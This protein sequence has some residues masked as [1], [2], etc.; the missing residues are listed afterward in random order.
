MADRASR[1]TTFDAFDA[2]WVRARLGRRRA[3][4]KIAVAD[5]HPGLAAHFATGRRAIAG[6]A[7]AQ[8]RG[9]ERVEVQGRRRR[10]GSRPSCSP[11]DEADM[12]RQWMLP[13]EFTPRLASARASGR[14][15]RTARCRPT[16]TAAPVPERRQWL[17]HPPGDHRLTYGSGGAPEH[18]IRPAL[19]DID[20]ARTPT[21]ARTDV[22]SA[23]LAP[24]RILAAV[25]ALDPHARRVRLRRRPPT[26]GVRAAPPRRA[27]RRRRAPRQRCPD[28]PFG[29][30]CSAVPPTARAASRAWPTTR[31]HGAAAA[32]RRWPPGPR[33]PGRHPGRLPEQ[34]GGRHRP[35]PGQRRLR[36]GTRRRPAGPAGRQPA[37]HRRADPSRHRRAGWRRSSWPARTPR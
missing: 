17:A 11:A 26:A 20:V 14:P 19:A 28:Q 23:L 21:G 25:A 18:A 8:H 9:I 36:G 31:W 33:G 35:R 30:G 15:P 22:T 5:R 2:Y 34:P 3:P 13:Y 29:I 24:R 10:T 12:W 37:A 16:T 1:P 32:T 27:R 7:W 4:I 6:V